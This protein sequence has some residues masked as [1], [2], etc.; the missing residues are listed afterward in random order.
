MRKPPRNPDPEALFEVAAA[1][2][3]HF[4]TS[5]AAEAGYSPQLLHKYL[6]S[7]KILRMRHGIY[8]MVHYPAGDHEHLV[9]LWLWS[10]Q[11]GVFGHET[12]L[13]LQDLGDALPARAHLTLPASWKQR[14]LR[15]PP[16]VDLHFADIDEE[17]KTWVGPVPVTDPART[18]R[19]CVADHVAP[20]LIRTAF[21]AAADRN[22]VDRRT[23][24]EVVTF[25]E[26]YFE[27]R[28]SKSGPTFR[29]RPGPAPT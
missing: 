2:E 29:D 24:P 14:R 12:A 23:L 22:L 19:D 3:G 13:A 11:E 7:N 27:K 20:D 1:Q 9:V 5:Q 10:G 21:E 6:Q 26:Q 28:R 15:I 17:E 8:R 4:T 16:G 18:L 25:L